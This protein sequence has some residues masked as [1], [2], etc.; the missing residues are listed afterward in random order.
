MHP[1][2]QSFKRTY[3]SS[4]RFSRRWMEGYYAEYR[5]TPARFDMLIVIAGDPAGI[6]QIDLRKTLDVCDSVVS[7]MLDSLQE[8]GYVGR[9]PFPQ[10]RRVNWVFLT[11]LGADVLAL[12]TQDLLLDGTNEYGVREVLA[13]HP[14]NESHTERTLARTRRFVRHLRRRVRDRSTLVYPAYF[15]TGERDPAYPYNRSDHVFVPQELRASP[16][17]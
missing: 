2:F 12:L 17:V 14:A 16:V 9:V 7:R 11:K 6:T 15:A 10:D 4:M 1:I 5:I 3:W 13:R 8:L